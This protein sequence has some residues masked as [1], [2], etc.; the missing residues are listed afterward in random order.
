MH[1]LVQPGLNIC[2]A[3]IDAAGTLQSLFQVLQ[4]A[5]QLFRLNPV[6]PGQVVLGTQDECRAARMT[7]ATPNWIGFDM[8]DAGEFRAEVQV[9]YHH[10]PAPCTVGRTE[11]GIEVEFDSPQLA[12]APGQGAAFYVG[13]R[14]LGG[15]WIE[16]SDLSAAASTS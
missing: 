7:V 9:R 15:G 2:Q 12:V 13:E 10:D 3:L 5:G 1:G 16:T 14:L 4:N 8:P 6:L 11:D